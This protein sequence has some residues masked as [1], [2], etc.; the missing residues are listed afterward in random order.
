MRRVLRWAVLLL[1]AALVLDWVAFKAQW[2]PQHPRIFACGAGALVALLLAAA[3]AAA[4][5]ALR[6]RERRGRALAEVSVLLGLVCV[7]AGG[8]ANWLFSLQGM[9]V[10][11]EAESAPLSPGGRLQEFEA[12]PLSDVD[13]MSLTLTLEKVE[14]APGRGGTFTPVSRLRV[15]RDG[16]PP[17]ELEVAAGRTALYRTLRFHQGAF[18]FAP[19]IVIVKGSE[20]L[21]DTVVPFTTERRGP[22]GISFHG[23]FTLEREALA[24]SGDVSLESLDERLRGHPTLDLSVRK[25]GEPLGRG[26]LVPGRFADLEGGYRIGFAGL[27]KWSEIDLSRRTYPLPIFIGLGMMLLG[28]L[29]WPLAL[30]RKW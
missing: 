6:R 22:A 11:A 16:Q 15:A 8:L 18:G 28:G 21:F 20:T 1:L 13:E 4:L 14:L 24:V 25:A 12:G 10:L 3:G 9:V 5:E 29:L 30:W 17:Q 27:K 7:A 23:E 19:R 26:A 2:L